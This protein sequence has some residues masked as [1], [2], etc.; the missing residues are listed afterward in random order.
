MWVVISHMAHF[1]YPDYFY[2]NNPGIKTYV[3]TNV[4]NS[5]ADFS[6]FTYITMI[7]FGLWCLGF[8]LSNLFRLEK[9]NNFLRRDDVVSF[10][11][12]NYIITFVLY[13]FFQL[14]GDSQPFGW[15]GNAPLSWHSVGTSIINHY[16]L[17]LCECIIF[18]RIKSGSSNKK[19]CYL[20][21]SI[22]LLVYY[23]VVKIVG[24]YAYNIRWF[25]YVIFDAKSFGQYIGVSNY[26]W[27]VVLLV[28]C[29]CA[30]FVVYQLLFY[31]LIRLK[32]CQQAKLIEKI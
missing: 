12:C 32:K 11:F 18:T 17:F 6:F 23:I 8:G 4:V 31:G 16:L 21:S 24:E 7:I 3:G 29:C 2:R 14:F 22:F 28:I 10:V 27:S 5:W 26:G 9:I 20:Y 13:T 30:L 1:S 25:P 15:F 19:R